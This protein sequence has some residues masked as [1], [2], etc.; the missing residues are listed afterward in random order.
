VSSLPERKKNQKV[1][2]PICV[3]L[4]MAREARGEL[5]HLIS[6]QVNGGWHVHFLVP[7]PMAQMTRSHVAH[8]VIG[9][10]TEQQ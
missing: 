8:L 4:A 10:R 1:G 5:C 3:P 6:A 2:T 9:P 7:V